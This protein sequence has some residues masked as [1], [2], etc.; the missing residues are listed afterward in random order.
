M[1]FTYS[2]DIIVNIT[3]ASLYLKKNESMPESV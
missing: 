2:I 1:L 3:G